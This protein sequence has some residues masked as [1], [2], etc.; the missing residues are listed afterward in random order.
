MTKPRL[1]F[2]PSPTG[3]LHIG[4]VRTDV[5]AKELAAESYLIT[6][7]DPALLEAFGIAGS[8]LPF[9]TG[10]RT[11]VLDNGLK[12]IIRQNAT[13]PGQAMVYLWI[14]SGSLGEEPDYPARVE[15]GAALLPRLGP[16]RPGRAGCDG[17]GVGQ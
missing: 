7:V 8:D 5:A 4:G 16:L 17:A 12:Y 1:R 6:P 11:G 10:Y 15:P 9:D 3:Y 14:K 13:P 2:A